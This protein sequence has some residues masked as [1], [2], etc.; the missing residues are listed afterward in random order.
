MKVL[1]PVLVAT[2]LAN[3]ITIQVHVEPTLTTAGTL[4]IIVMESFM[5]HPQKAQSDSV[6]AGWERKVGSPI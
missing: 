1:P 6:S 2:A 5:K 4:V 3:P